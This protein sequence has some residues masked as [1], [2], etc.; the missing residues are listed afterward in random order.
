MKTMDSPGET[1]HRASG[2]QGD[3]E[4]GELCIC[5]CLSI[6][7]EELTARRIRRHSHGYKCGEDV[8]PMIVTIFLEK[9][10]NITIL[11]EKY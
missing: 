4:N 1:E 10:Q 8:H 11:Y 5:V 6:Q 7:P 3:C 2:G 9:C